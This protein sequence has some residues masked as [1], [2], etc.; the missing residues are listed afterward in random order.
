MS[1]FKSDNLLELITEFKKA[2][3]YVRT[4]NRASQMNRHIGDSLGSFQ[5]QSFYVLR[6]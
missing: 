5:I 6:T 4:Q 2:L 1:P 3:Q